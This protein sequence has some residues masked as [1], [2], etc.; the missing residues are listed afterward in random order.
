MRLKEDFILANCCHPGVE[1]DITGY[2]SHDRF[3]KVHKSSCPNLKKA[4]SGRL[5]VLEWRNIVASDDFKPD[6]D[7]RTLDGVDF[8]ILEH[9]HKLGVDYSLKVAAD[10]R[11]ER[12]IVFDRHRKLRAMGL[13]E[14][15]KPVMIQYRKNIVKNKWIK[16]RNHTYYNLT[17][18]GRD[19]LDYYS[20][21]SRI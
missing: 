21:N 3:I 2:F 11:I 17:L 7:Y 16:H 8:A 14:R 6:E 19:Y 15:V 10:L 13:L 9:H 4:D 1:D 20:R 5:I 18:K 12:H